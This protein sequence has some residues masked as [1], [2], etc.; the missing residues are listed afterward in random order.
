MI[1]ILSNLHSNLP[2]LAEILSRVEK[3]KEEGVDVK[4]VYILS[5]FGLMPYPEETYKLLSGSQGKI[6]SVVAGKYD[7][8]LAKWND[9]SD[10][11]KEELVGKE[12]MDVIDLYWDM[13]GHEG[14]K[15]VR[16]MTE[17]FI[18]EKFDWNE[19]Y[20]TYGLLENPDEMPAEK[21]PPTYYEAKFADLKKYEVIAVAGREPY[22]VNT[23]IGKIVCP[24][25]AGL[26][27]EPTFALVDTK[28]L[29]VS[30]ETFSYNIKEVEDRIKELNV[31]ETT[32]EYLKDILYRGR[33]FP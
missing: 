14:R 4:K 20:F 11:E 19:F 26:G 21:Q 28:T 5:A 25:I 22:A 10:E 32:K 13:L 33:P 31:P 9:L 16:N 12:L 29:H 24:G 8:L 17:R 27:R 1:A 6:I 15:W 23:K 30:F 2:A 7:R 3:L 18:A